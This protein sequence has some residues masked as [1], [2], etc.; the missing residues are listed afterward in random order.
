MLDSIKQPLTSAFNNM[1]F[2]KVRNNISL[3]NS[4][5]DPNR[6][7]SKSHTAESSAPVSHYFR[8]GPLLF[9]T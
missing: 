2:E 5:I 4:G 3:I 9:T 6:R 1:G 7:F 8:E